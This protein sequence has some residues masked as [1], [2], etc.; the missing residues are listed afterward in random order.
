MN[1]LYTKNDKDEVLLFVSGLASELEY[2]QMF[3][4]CL[5]QLWKGSSARILFIIK[6][7][8]KCQEFDIEEILTILE[9]DIQQDDLKTSKMVIEL[10][11]DKVI[12]STHHGAS[13]RDY[14]HHRKWLVFSR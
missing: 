6:E 7:I 14:C 5:K 12:W 13:P 4:E 10:T 2:P 1:I 3:A 8:Q 11:N 9:Q